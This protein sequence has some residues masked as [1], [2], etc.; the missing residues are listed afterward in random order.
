[1]IDISS[2]QQWS[3]TAVFLGIERCD[4]KVPLMMYISKMAPFQ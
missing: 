3:P 2:A 1:M 4:S